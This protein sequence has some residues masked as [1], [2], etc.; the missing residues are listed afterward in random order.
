M[1]ILLAFISGF[2]VFIAG[3]LF[4]YM[5]RNFLRNARYYVGVIKVTREE[6]RILYSLEFDEDPSELEKMNEVVFKVETSEESS[7]RK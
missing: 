2:I 7:D 3:F 6:N 4:G 5:M 1:N